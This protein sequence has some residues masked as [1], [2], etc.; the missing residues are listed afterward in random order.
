[1]ATV[2]DE[3]PT[4]RTAPRAG[5]AAGQPAIDADLRIPGR[6]SRLSRHEPLLIGG[7]AV[8]VVLAIWQAVASARVLPPL[9]LPGPLDIVQTFALLFWP[10]NVREQFNAAPWDV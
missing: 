1:M 3:A 9:F 4:K 2:R 10:I 7:S 5:P 6:P 8:I